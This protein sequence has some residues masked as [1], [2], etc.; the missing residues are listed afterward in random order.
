MHGPKF[1]ESFDD[2]LGFVLPFLGAPFAVSTHP[3]TASLL[4]AQAS[5][6]PAAKLKRS[7]IQPVRMGPKAIPRDQQVSSAAGRRWVRFDLNLTLR[8]DWEHKK[9]QEIYRNGPDLVWAEKVMDLGKRNIKE[10]GP[11][12]LMGNPTLLR[13]KLI[14]FVNTN[15]FHCH[16]HFWTVQ[17]V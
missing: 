11:T 6:H 16:S 13:N 9:K 17:S 8:I 1:S 12:T 3:G 4:S 10:L 15:Q 2:F 14:G 7:E 5:S